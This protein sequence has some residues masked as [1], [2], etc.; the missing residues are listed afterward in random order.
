MFGLLFTFSITHMTTTTTTT[1][2]ANS[3]FKEETN[4][5][6][7]QKPKISSL[8]L[9]SLKQ[10]YDLF[11]RR[12]LETGSFQFEEDFESKRLKVNS[13]ILEEYRHVKD[14]PPPQPQTTAPTKEQ[15]TPQLKPEK[16]EIEG[17]DFVDNEGR[18]V[19]GS[20]NFP[21]GPG[22]KFVDPTSLPLPKMFSF[23]KNI[24]FPFFN[25]KE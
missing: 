11:R 13:K 5:D 3:F 20:H 22:S 15:T 14:L 25:R 1:T 2:T 23:I 21:S 7:L 8:C 10:T 24:H 19:V 6:P 16:M 18:V 17:N 4:K 12:Q 9:R